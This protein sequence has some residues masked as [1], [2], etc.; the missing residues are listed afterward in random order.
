M[1]DM[2]ATSELGEEGSEYIVAHF[3]HGIRVDSADDAAFV[4]GLALKYGMAFEQ[5][6][7]ELGAG[8]SEELARQRRYVFLGDISRKYDAK[9]VTAHHGDDVIET[10]AINLQRGT[11]WRGLAVMDNPDVW[12]PL[13][14]MSKADLM[15]YAA[16]NNLTWREDSTNADVRYLR[17][18]LRKKL[19]GLDD[20]SKEGLRLY[21]RRQVHLKR[22]INHEAKLLAGQSHYSRYKLIMMP[23]QAATEVL[24]AIILLETGT[25]L[26]RPQLERALMAI[27]TQHSGKRYEAGEGVSLA[28]TATTYIVEATNK[29]I[30]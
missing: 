1:L 30:S 21:W 12:R 19:V 22:L 18:D 6:R 5:R 17:N 4:E 24:R 3:D 11:G 7:E 15:S 8:A 10:I 27:K 23:R 29:V 13:L 20:R 26:L 9:I 25:S 28:F 14:D 2:F 16:R